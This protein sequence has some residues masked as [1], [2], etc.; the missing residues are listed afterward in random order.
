MSTA[1]VLAKRLRVGDWVSFQFG[2][3]RAWA[4]VIE[5]RGRLGVKGQRYYRIRLDQTATDPFEFEMPADELELAVPD[6]PAI[7]N[8]LKT[9]GLVTILQ[10]H[11]IRSKK[12]PRRVA[13]V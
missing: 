7:L 11:L 8:Y 13:H 3:R 9:G 5:D 1:K 12:P 4:Q 6:K 2:P 10:A